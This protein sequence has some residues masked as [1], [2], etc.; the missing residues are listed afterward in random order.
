MAGID[1]SKLLTTE[2]I[3]RFEKYWGDDTEALMNELR[4]ALAF[5][6]EP[7]DRDD[8]ENFV[9]K[10]IMALVGDAPDL[11]AWQA[12]LLEGSFDLTAKQDYAASRQLKSRA[13]FLALTS[14]RLDSEIETLRKKFASVADEAQTGVR[15]ILCSLILIAMKRSA[16]A[17]LAVG[18]A[19]AVTVAV[20]KNLTTEEKKA[21]H[22][23]GG[24][25]RLLR[26]LGEAVREAIADHLEFEIPSTSERPASGDWAR[27]IPPGVDPAEALRDEREIDS[28]PLI[29]NEY[30]REMSESEWYASLAEIGS[31]QDAL[32]EA[33][34]EVAHS[35]RQASTVYHRIHEMMPIL[36]RGD[37]ADE[38]IAMADRS[39]DRQARL[40]KSPGRST[41]DF[42]EVFRHLSDGCVFTSVLEDC[43]SESEEAICA[44]F[45]NPMF[46]DHVIE[47]LY[48]VGLL[49]KYDRQTV[50]DRRKQIRE[51]RKPVHDPDDDWPEELG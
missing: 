4:S 25:D 45:C 1:L 7:Q 23:Y 44:I 46:P 11:E 38:I 50:I 32:I 33:A 30:D 21:L 48:S 5:F 36:V 27:T 3:E 49:T 14:F 40:K 47:P 16:N 35:T 26:R 2:Q 22:T 17:R 28:D 42:Y 6:T 19:W 41:N 39:D 29:P 43:P 37:R 31:H 20:D 10:L 8:M 13:R 9:E 24:D 15:L 18:P 12:T 51:E 34:N